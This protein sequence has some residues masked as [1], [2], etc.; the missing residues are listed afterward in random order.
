MDGFPHPSQWRLRGGS[1]YAAA[2]RHGS[3]SQ[4]SNLMVSAFAVVG[5]RGSSLETHRCCAS[6]VCSV[7]VLLGSKGLKMLVVICRRGCWDMN[8]VTPRYPKVIK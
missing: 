7:R 8:L 1:S 6:V 2:I 5:G 3:G 4:S